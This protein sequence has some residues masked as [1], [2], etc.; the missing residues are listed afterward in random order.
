[1]KTDPTKLLIAGDTHRD[2]P[3]IKYLFETAHKYKCDTIVQLGDFG[4]WRNTPEGR[5]FTRFVYEQS[6]KHKIPF[7]WIEGNHECVPDYTRV[8]TR[9]GLTSWRTVD[10]GDE[11]LSVDD[12]GNSIFTPVIDKIVRK[13]TGPLSNITSRSVS[14]EATPGHR[15]IYQTYVKKEWR[16]STLGMIEKIPYGCLTTAGKNKNTKD[17][18]ISDDEIRLVAWLLTDGSR[19]HD[20]GY[21]R[22]YQRKSNHFVIEKLLKRLNIKFGISKRKRPPPVINGK[23]CKTAQEENTFNISAE[24]SRNVCDRL[25]QDRYRLPKKFFT[26]SPRQFDIFINEYVDGDG[27]IGTNVK[28]A[29]VIYINHDLLRDDIQALCV[30]N[31][32]NAWTS[33]LRDG[34]Y[35]LNI[36]RRTQYVLMNQPYITLRHDEQY[37]GLVWCFK[38]QN[39]R[40]FIE[41]N[42]KIHL[43]G[44]C[45][46]DI[47]QRIRETWRRTP[48]GFVSLN[49][50]ADKDVYNKSIYDVQEAPPQNFN[51]GSTN[52]PG[53]YYIPRGTS[54]TW[55]GVRFLGLG[56][57]FSVDKAWRIEGVSWFRQEM[58]TN[59]DVEK[60]MDA[61]TCDVMLT[62]DVPHGVPEIEAIRE[63]QTDTEIN[64]FSKA[65][66][67]ALRAA[68]DAAQPQLLVHGHLHSYYRS[69]LRLDQ[70]IFD[71]NIVGLD[72]DGSGPESWMIL[73]LNDRPPYGKVG[74][75]IEG[76]N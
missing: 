30:Q 8:I 44:N 45:F 21:W 3:Q 22:I 40:F 61:G 55:N 63:W 59:A 11:I 28:T 2:I 19:T 7:L 5:K 13:Y 57:A 49:D 34:D 70:A 64:N 68:A 6:L 46:N 14:I 4:F 52:E 9:N 58:I 43:T 24:D 15:F 60:C 20:Y 50:C 48:E 36:C 27:S 67:L 42:N 26:L 62:H 18:E 51:C 39:G 74:V 69:K 76:V 47:D 65:N 17:V 10:L 35:R 75:E 54:W 33:K 73:D 41:Q 1:M 16:E 53:L 31:G 29:R 23:Q 25:V 66:R 32:M 38:V 71:T 56:G 37:N 72:C 12:Y